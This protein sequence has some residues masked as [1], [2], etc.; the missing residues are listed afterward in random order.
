MR[1]LSRRPQGDDGMTLAEL[2]VSMIIGTIV[3]AAVAAVFVG[4]TRTSRAVNARV[5]TTADARVA[6][7]A[8][9]RGLRVAVD[10]PM[11]SAPSAFVTAT[12]SSVKF[13]ASVTQ[14]GVATDPA[15]TLVSYQYDS[16]KRC[17]SRTR[18]PAAGTSPNFTF[19]SGAGTTC[20][21]YGTLGAGGPLFSYYTT[22]QAT[23]PIAVVNGVVTAADLPS[24]QSVGINLV[25][26]DPNTPSAPATVVKDRVSLIN[27]INAGN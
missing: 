19:T 21:A 14:P 11:P 18:T 1:G 6:M 16:V 9:T 2:S 22:G 12:T 20:L 7:E 8:M 5:S 23:I 27:V 17:L 15:P 13:Y 10:P 4:A 24:I 26:S 3:L 25:L